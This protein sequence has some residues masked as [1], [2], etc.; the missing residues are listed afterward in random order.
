[1][2]QQEA[3]SQ[4]QT[5]FPPP[6]R[7][8]D[9][10][11]V[12]LLLGL[13]LVL[14][15]WDLESPALHRDEALIGR[16]AASIDFSQALET[17]SFRTLPLQADQH[18]GTWMAYAVYPFLKL[19][20]G[21]PVAVRVAG[22]VYGF[23]GLAAMFCLTHRLFGRAPALFF[24][25]LLSLHPSFLCTTRLGMI[26]GNLMYL[27]SFAALFFLWRWWTDGRFG[28][29]LWTCF[30]LGMGVGILSWFIYALGA[31][32][33]AMSLK[34]RGVAERV[35]R[36]WR[37]YLLGGGVS[38][39]AGTGPLFLAVLTG[40][41]LPEATLDYFIGFWTAQGAGSFSSAFFLAERLRSFVK[42]L[43]G[44][45]TYLNHWGLPYGQGL[46]YPGLFLVA[47]VWI[48]ATEVGNFRRRREA[49]VLPALI[50]FLAAYLLL[51][52]FAPSMAKELHL[53][54][55]LPLAVLIT[56]I[57]LC[58]LYGKITHLPLKRLAW[59]V[60]C[61]LALLS[62]AGGNF[63]NYDYLRRTGGEFRFQSWAFYDLADWVQARGYRRVVSVAPSLNVKLKF[64]AS[65]KIVPVD[66]VLTGRHTDQQIV[67]RLDRSRGWADAYI[68]GFWFK[69]EDRLP[70]KFQ[71]FSRWR[72]KQ[73]PP[74]RLVA[75]FHERQGRPIYLVYEPLRRPVVKDLKKR[76]E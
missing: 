53:L 23:L 74:P 68:A 64:M 38:F 75:V 31:L 34:A 17:W 57:G 51:S 30:F 19:F 50:V 13:F 11:L 73:D 52:S 18:H 66:L 43:G 54:P 59:G 48:L 41:M 24:L 46:V 70:T 27:V 12:F 4:A 22:V 26:D 61:G 65:S 60:T 3:P 32:G 56:A 28:H 47:V 16:L 55:L 45:Y 76:T 67:S 35:G 29:F 42:V 6:D 20:G 40:E 69:G 72:R 36:R 62:S 25:L 71:L 8:W 39:L 58:G 5:F 7:G 2:T 9:R 14:A 44:G 10:A 37:W 63:S 21:Q 33:V 49:G 15:V 1:M